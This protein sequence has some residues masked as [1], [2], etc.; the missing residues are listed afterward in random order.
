MNVRNIHIE[1]KNDNNKRQQQQQQK[2]N[3][4]T[5]ESETEIWMMEHWL[6]SDHMTKINTILGSKISLVGV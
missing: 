2:L 4:L 1:E 3:L 6:T 5:C